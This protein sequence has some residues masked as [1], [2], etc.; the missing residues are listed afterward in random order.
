ME[1]FP[2][3]AQIAFSILFGLSDLFILQNSIEFHIISAITAAEDNRLFI[4]LKKH[5]DKHSGKTMM[6]IYFL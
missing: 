6:E 5:Y 1:L 4:Y 2:K 3:K